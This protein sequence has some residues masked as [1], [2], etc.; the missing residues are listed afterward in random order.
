[1]AFTRPSRTLY[2]RC[3]RDV[4][5][6]SPPPC[7]SGCRYCRWSY[8]GSLRCPAFPGGTPCSTRSHPRPPPRSTGC[9][10]RLQPS[11]PARFR[12][13][14]FPLPDRRDCRRRPLLLPR[15]V[16]CVH[17]RF[18]ASAAPDSSRTSA[19]IRYTRAACTLRTTRML[20][21]PAGVVAVFGTRHKVSG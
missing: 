11:G 8:S 5:P 16:V 1:M 9:T 18:S 3:R 7:Y 15:F 4:L 17:L 14:W 6:R 19:R 20:P 13:C 21:A 12:I 10:P 2:C